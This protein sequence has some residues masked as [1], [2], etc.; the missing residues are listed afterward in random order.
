MTQHS[1]IDQ[2]LVPVNKA[3]G[4]PN[5]HYI[6]QEIF[7]EEKHSVLFK[8]WS[9][10]GFGV[11]VPNSGDAKP[12]DFLGI[13]LVIVRDRDGSVGVFQN[14]CR[15]RGM[16]L[17]DEPKNIRGT[18][19]CPYHSWCYN[20]N[21]SLRSTP[22][23]GGPGNNTHEDIDCDELGLVRIRSYIW[24]DVVFVNIS[25]DAPEFEEAHKDLLDRWKEFDQPMFHGGKTSSFKLEVETNWKLAVENYC[26][27]YH[28][29]WIHPGLNSYSRLEDHYNI[30]VRDAYS[31]QGTY[32]YKQLK[33]DDGQVFPDFDNLSDQWDEGAE[34]IAVYPNV[35]MGIHRDHFYSILLEPVQ[36]DRTVEH[37]EIYYPEDCQSDPHFGELLTT[38]AQ[39]WKRI[40][41]EDLFV[42]EGMQK[43][44]KGDL[45]DGGKFSPAMDGP[46]HN[47]H[48]WV[49]SQI[50]RNRRE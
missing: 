16:I 14:T 8:N 35:L 39:Q 47:F 26:E 30:E 9:G 24:K 32:V 40:F 10:I 49:A 31:G 21:G 15:H 2:V 44:R 17:I 50:K 20:L 42:V 11:D 29:P 25:A 3:K 1:S 43:G 12:I 28:L 33:G 48:H 27:A 22:H 46:T 5:E 13:P 23:V 34:Y 19:R 45:F 7:V 36:M 41:E 38:N 4:L 6:S 37:V 18:I